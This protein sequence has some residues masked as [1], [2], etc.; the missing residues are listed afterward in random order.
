MKALKVILVWVVCY[1]ITVHT[2]KA[3]PEALTKI[4]YSRLESLTSDIKIQIIK[5]IIGQ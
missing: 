2:M 5:D 1:N 4:T 3:P